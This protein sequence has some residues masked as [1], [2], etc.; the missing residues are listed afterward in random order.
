[1]NATA[2]KITESYRAD[3]DGAAQW[4]SALRDDI[5]DRFEAI[6]SEFAYDGFPSGRFERTPWDYKGEGGGVMSLM[7]GS[8]FEKVGVNFSAVSGN[9]PE[10]FRGKIPGA[11]ESDGNFFAC[12][13]SLVAHMRNPLVPAVHMNTRYIE[14][15]KSWYGGGA[16]L[17]PTFPQQKDTDDFHAAFKAVCDDYDPTAYDRYKKWCDDYF[18]LPHRGEP[19]GVGGVFFDYLEGEDKNADFA[20]VRNI[21]K[22]FADIY[23]AVVRRHAAEP[24][25]Q[26]QR[27]KLLYKRGR[28]VEFNLIH[29]R[30]TKFG[31]AT[32]GNIDAILMSLPPEAKW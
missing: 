22:A 27:E 29:D 28:Y 30:G 12:G 26:E 16:D 23:P 9:F 19:R 7:R 14:T 13:I 32:G 15:S 17:T 11:V 1:M 4:F 31:L 10:E 3:K 20:F 8:V 5:C 18:F 6:E 25:T 24:W 2:E 21:G